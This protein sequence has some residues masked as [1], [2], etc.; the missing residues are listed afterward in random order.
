MITPPSS[1][2]PEIKLPTMEHVLKYDNERHWEERYEKDRINSNY[3][4][5]GQMNP[6]MTYEKTVVFFATFYP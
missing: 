1:D 2:Q 5:Y 6:Y 3:L 4:V